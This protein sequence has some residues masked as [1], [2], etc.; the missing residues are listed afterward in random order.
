MHAV[1][2]TPGDDEPVSFVQV[3]QPAQTERQAIVSV[4][5]SSVNR[6]ELRMLAIQPHGWRPGRDV[7]GVVTRSAPDGTGPRRG[8]RVVGLVDGGGW[9]ESVAVDASR[10]VELP[11]SVTMEQAAALPTAGLAALRS[12]RLGGS[13][14]G[15]RVLVTGANGGV[16][17][18]HLQFAALSG[19]E[20]SAVT[21]RAEQVEKE[22]KSLGATEVVE[23]V[24]DAGAPFDLVLESVGG[25]VL[26]AALSQVAPGGTV[27]LLG[28]SSGEKTPVDVHDLA[29]GGGARVH[30]FG[31][32]LNTEP[33]GA[34]LEVLVDL[35]AAGR[36]RAEPGHTADWSRLADV[37]RLVRDRGLSGG[38]A[39]VTMR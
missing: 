31:P 11:H 3:G 33:D 36:V 16:G 37:L 21:T 29:G 23:C 27:V 8:A 4:Y 9:S 30:S 35:V 10:L 13:L 28:S 1:I 24:E 20:V 22:L 2:A 7:A 34:D 26:A 15:R 5:A 17:R 19:A 14:L 32:G 12:L 39:V 6:D 38:K 18:F 25:R